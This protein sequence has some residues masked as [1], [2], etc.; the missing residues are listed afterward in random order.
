MRKPRRPRRR[1]SEVR[2]L[3][4]DAARELFA[5]RGYQGTTTRQVAERADVT[6]ILI[7]SHFKTKANLFEAAVV[8]PVEAEFGDVVQ[9][10]D[11]RLEAEQ[12]AGELSYWALDC[13]G[14]IYDLFRKNRRLLITLIAAQAHDPELARRLR[15]LLGRL[16]VMTLDSA[17]SDSVFDARACL[18]VELVVGGVLAAAVHSEL[19]FDAATEPTREAVLKYFAGQ[20][21]A[22]GANRVAQHARAR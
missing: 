8:A 3:M 9:R 7:Y 16:L 2:Q 17:P 15:R 22:A 12:A 21:R 1:S 20:L 14:E 11:R 6:E 19:L 4:L 10:R 18:A 5:E 13:V